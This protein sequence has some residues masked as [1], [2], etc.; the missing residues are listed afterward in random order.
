V[1]D[2]YDSQCESNKSLRIY[3][4]LGKYDCI[5]EFKITIDRGLVLERLK[6]Y[7]REQLVDFQKRCI[8]PSPKE[9]FRG[10]IQ[11]V[12]ESAYVHKKGP[13]KAIQAPK[14]SSTKIILLKSAILA[15]HQSM[16]LNLFVVLVR[17]FNAL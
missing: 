12:Q 3:E 7:L 2:L 1:A 8:L 17:D 13:F 4:Q 5:C 10:S 16:A 15:A 9:E 6:Q 14:I 11:V